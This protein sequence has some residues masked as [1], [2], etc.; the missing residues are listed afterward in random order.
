MPLVSRRFAGNE[1]LQ[2]AARNAPAL[3]SGAAGKGVELL[4]AAL[5]DLGFP[6]AVS[7]GNGAKRADGVY[8]P[9]TAKTVRDFQ[10]GAGL[11]AD[12]IAGRD[13]LTRLDQIVATEE[14]QRQASAA[15]ERAMNLWT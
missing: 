5:L 12:G 4:Q 13:T 11:S 6:M 8:G 9:E 2:A 15:A 7:T 10:S 3:R 1:Q 14:G